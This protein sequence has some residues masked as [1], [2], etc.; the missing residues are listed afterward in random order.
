M[1]AQACM[2]KQRPED[3]TSANLYNPYTYSLER[4][5]LIKQQSSLFSAE[6]TGQ[7][8]PRIHLSVLQH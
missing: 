3:N 1:C 5:S 7:Q 8:S 4:G 6:L 2:G